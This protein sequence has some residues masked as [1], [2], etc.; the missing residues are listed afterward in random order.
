[1]TSGPPQ[2]LFGRFTTGNHETLDRDGNREAL[3]AFWTE[4]YK[5]D[6]MTLSII[7]TQ[8]IEEL[9]GW[10][11]TIFAD[12]P[13]SMPIIGGNFNDRCLCQSRVASHR[14]SPATLERQRSESRWARWK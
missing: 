9:E 4:H 2:S 6:R 7:G 5:A 1:M 3:L 13:S 11:A 10:A 12:I 8:S 14:L